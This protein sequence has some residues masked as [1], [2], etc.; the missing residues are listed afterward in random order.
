MVNEQR[1]DIDE[2][3]NRCRN[4]QAKQHIAEAVACYKVGAF[5]SCIVATW[6][7]IVFDYIHKL[8][9]LDD[10]GDLKANV[11]VSELDIIQRGNDLSAS[12][13][14][15]NELLNVARND[16]EL[17]SLVQQNELNDLHKTR[18][19]CAHPSMNVDGETYQPTPALTLHCI[20]IAIEYLLRHPPV[21]GKAALERLTREVNSINFP[22]TQDSVIAHFELSPL[23]KARE[24]LIRNFVICLLKTVVKGQL[25]SDN[26][27]RHTLAFNAVWRKYPSITEKVLKDKL[28]E[29]MISL[30]DEEFEIVIKRLRGIDD[31]GKFI[32]EDVRELRRNCLNRMY[33]KDPTSVILIGLK[34]ERLR[35]IIVKNLKKVGVQQL[36]NLVKTEPHPEFVPRAVELYVQSSSWKSANKLGTELIIPLAKYLTEEYIETI[37]KGISE[38]KEV[39]G[40]FKAK[41]VLICIQSTNIISEEKFNSLIKKYSLEKK[42]S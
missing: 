29:L 11:R 20:Q 36:L 35:R 19:R 3:V 37:I 12:L 14:F 2:L 40:S 9:E 33:P 27:N 38:N 22:D 16:F 21:Q 28:N 10:L 8:R 4:E 24:S 26:E 23:S 5:R 41:D 42:L 30:N 15:E 31:Y 18:H 34:D 7:A 6:L 25:D 39:E 17:I 32:K 13:D 1:I